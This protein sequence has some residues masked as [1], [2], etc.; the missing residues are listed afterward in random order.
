MLL[1][2]LVKLTERH[3][4]AC[5]LYRDYTD[6]TFADVAVAGEAELL[7]H[8]AAPFVESGRGRDERRL[9]RRTGGRAVS[10][11]RALR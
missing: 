2:E 7:L 11:W 1:D 6:S 5:P 10:R 8:E 3:R 4:L 9:V